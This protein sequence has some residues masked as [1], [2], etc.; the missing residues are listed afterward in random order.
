[1]SYVQDDILNQRIVS[2]AN[3]VREDMNHKFALQV[4]EN[5]RLSSQ[6]NIGQCA[7]VPGAAFGAA[8]RTGELS[9]L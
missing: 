1:M 9:T 3:N 2:E 6:V 5:K 8:G 4:A 7:H